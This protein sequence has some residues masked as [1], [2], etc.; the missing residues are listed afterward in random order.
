[1]TSVDFLKSFEERQKQREKAHRMS[2]EEFRV[3]RER[4]ELSLLDGP[5]C[6]VC[7]KP[8][9]EHPDETRAINNQIVCTD[10]YWEKLGELI[11]KHPIVCPR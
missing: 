11:A 7:G 1:M 8:V 5:F 10:C 2:P 9:E 4:G 6:T 3:A